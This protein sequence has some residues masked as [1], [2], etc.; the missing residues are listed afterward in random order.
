MRVHGR[1]RTVGIK[2]TTRKQRSL[3]DKV[4]V[5]AWR[6]LFF[7]NIEQRL[8]NVA[9]AD[10]LSGAT[11]LQTVQCMHHSLAEAVCFLG[12]RLAAG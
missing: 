4:D 8:A 9:V 2:S 7:D 1:Y 5:M 12:N 3:F 6:D 11:C 10:K